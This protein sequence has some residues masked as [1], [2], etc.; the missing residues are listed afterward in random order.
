MA[1]I[2]YMSLFHIREDGMKRVS[3]HVPDSMYEA[4]HD[5]ASQHQMPMSLYTRVLVG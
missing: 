3:V 5:F 2:I 1:I 4:L